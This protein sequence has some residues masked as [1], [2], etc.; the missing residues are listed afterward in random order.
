MK[1]IKISKG[2]V[3]IV[4]D[5]D[6]ED[7]I[8]FKWFAEVRSNTQIYTHRNAGSG[9]KD[10]RIERMHRRIM[11]APKGVN[12]D[13]ING[14]GLD[15]RKCNLRLATTAQNGQNVGKR[16][17]NKSGY[18]GVSPAKGG[19][20][21]AHIQVARVRYYLGTYKDINKAAEAYNAAAIKHHGEFAYINKIKA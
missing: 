2:Y 16:S 18:K 9:R 7:L 19:Y 12:I 15:N 5:E 4:D 20:W 13:H 17:R 1:E 10:V 3:T 11:K 21:Q 8:Q 6:Y 14:N